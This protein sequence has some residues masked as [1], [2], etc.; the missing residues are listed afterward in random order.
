MDTDHPRT[1]SSPPSPPRILESALY[2]DDLEA[3]AAFY[4]DLL[5]FEVLVDGDRLVALSVPGPQVLLLFRQ[6]ASVQGGDGD[7]GG[8]IPSHDARGRAHLGFAV[9]EDEYEAWK[10]RLAEEG[11]DVEH[12]MEWP[13]GGR[14][15]YFRD[16]HGHLLEMV[17]PGCWETY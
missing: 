10:E 8:G 17:T 12:E 9:A 1:S 15:F 4:R 16:P 13:R 14:S 5:G 7:E 6:G 2:V 11:V 3:A